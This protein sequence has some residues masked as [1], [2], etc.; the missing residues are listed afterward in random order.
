MT[1]FFS[2][3]CFHTAAAGKKRRKSGKHTPPPLP[4]DVFHNPHSRHAQV[5]DRL[6]YHLVGASSICVV[7]TCC[8]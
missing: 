6:L 1:I 7:V 4:A 3:Q 5:R 8:H 2:I